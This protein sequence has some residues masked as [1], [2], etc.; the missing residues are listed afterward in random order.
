MKVHRL[1]ISTASLVSYSK[2]FH[3][4]R[5]IPVK[6]GTAAVQDTDSLF[7][8]VGQVRN[9]SSSSRDEVIQGPEL[10]QDCKLSVSLKRKTKWINS[11]WIEKFRATITHYNDLDISDFSFSKF[12]RTYK[13]IFPRSI[14][15]YQLE[16]YFGILRTWV[17]TKWSQLGR[18]KWDS[19]FLVNFTFSATRK[20]QTTIVKR[21]EN[22][23]QHKSLRP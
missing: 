14:Q 20:R 18:M 12:R 10:P 6:Q 16:R 1:S 2:P 7:H 23:A 4:G 11:T 3:P 21:K 19:V 8:I 17:G 15:L 9:A 22:S 13:N 5:V